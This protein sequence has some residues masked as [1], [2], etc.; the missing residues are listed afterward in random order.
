MMI[1]FINFKI[2]IFAYH[3]LFFLED[4]GLM[5]CIQHVGLNS[6]GQLLF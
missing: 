5:E 2:F 3:F 6:R 1:F 4:S